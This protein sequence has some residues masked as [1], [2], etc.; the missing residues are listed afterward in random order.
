MNYLQSIAQSAISRSETPVNNGS[1]HN[2]N[3]NG[4]GFHY[5]QESLDSASKKAYG[6]LLHQ[7]RP[8]TVSEFH[9]LLFFSNTFLN[10]DHIHFI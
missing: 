6:G 2:G 1:E 10:L 4:N 8:S 5:R 3:G 7:K 9:L